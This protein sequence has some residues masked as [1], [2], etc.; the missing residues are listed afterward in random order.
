MTA[1]FG[2]RKGRIRKRNAAKGNGEGIQNERLSIISNDRTSIVSSSA[3]MSQYVSNISSNTL[4][5][6]T[7][8]KLQQIDPEI[9]L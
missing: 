4:D 2:D 9:F 5:D 1:S 3:N 8:F 7:S 6:Y